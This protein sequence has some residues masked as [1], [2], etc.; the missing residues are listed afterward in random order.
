MP[1]SSTQEPTSTKME[2]IP[3]AS[4]IKRIP[5]HRN[6]NLPRPYLPDFSDQITYTLLVNLARELR[7]GDPNYQRLLAVIPSD[8]KTFRAT[9]AG[10]HFAGEIPRGEIDNGG[11]Q[12][13]LSLSR[14]V[15]D[16]PTSQPEAR[17]LIAK[18]AQTNQAVGFI[19]VS[20]YDLIRDALQKPENPYHFQ[21]LLDILQNP[22]DRY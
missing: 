10:R 12:L 6:P 1:E 16:I 13:L 20:T 21:R 22:D 2:E 3:L 8:F 4:V 15:L 11:N 5:L 17:L 9:T 19:N 14:T 7:S 18:D